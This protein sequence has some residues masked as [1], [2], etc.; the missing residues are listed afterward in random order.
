MPDSAPEGPTPPPGSETG[1]GQ[2]T[3]GPAKPDRDAEETAARIRQEAEA[4]RRRVAEDEAKQAAERAQEAQTKAGPE[5][6]PEAGLEAVARTLPQEQAPPPAPEAA[7]P[8]GGDVT[9]EALGLLRAI[10]AH[11]IEAVP[12]VNLTRIA[13]ESGVEITP[14]MTPNQVIDRLREKAGAQQVTPEA[15]RAAIDTFAEDATEAARQRREEL[16]TLTLEDI[17]DDIAYQ[18]ARMEGASHT[19][20]TTRL[21]DE[22]YNEARKIMADADKEIK[23]LRNLR[24]Q[25]VRGTRT[26]GTK[27][28]S[29]AAGRAARQQAEEAARLTKM[30]LADLRDER[31]IAKATANQLEK[32][33]ENIDPQD[34]VTRRGIEAELTRMKAKAEELERIYDEKETEQKKADQKTE[35]ERLEKDFRTLQAEMGPAV[36]IQKIVDSMQKEFNDLKNQIVIKTEALGK[37]ADPEDREKLQGEISD[38]KRRFSEAGNNLK[39]EKESLSAARERERE[40]AD[41]S[42]TI[43]KE[44]IRHVSNAEY[45]KFTPEQKKERILE[46]ARVSPELNSIAFGLLRTKIESGANLSQDEMGQFV[47]YASTGLIRGDRGLLNTV[48]E[49]TAHYSEIGPAVLAQVLATREAQR[50]LREAN[51]SDLEKIWKFAS[52]YK[53]WM[54]ILLLIIAG[55]T[56]G[57]AVGVGTL[58]AGGTGLAGT[59][60]GG[61][62][63]IGLGRRSNA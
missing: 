41:S 54:A 18:K 22:T 24:R 42:T 1:G 60:A 45:E 8:T 46:L 33:L 10:D 61:A 55:A 17:D 59:G 58:A 39:A 26:A 53:G 57:V 36:Q 49:A 43:A 4:S 5:A 32:Q 16:R 40:E 6:G 62:G 44:N 3:D 52:K 31:D 38:L 23:E 19:L 12:T 9:Q 56:A 25:S 21:P 20:N 30:P 7:A 15:A 34:V 14:G 28:E 51:P 13:R 63:V 48:Y 11:G 50:A 29:E 47:R 2:G 37:T 35:E 27:S